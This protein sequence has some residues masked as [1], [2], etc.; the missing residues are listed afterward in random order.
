MTLSTLLRIVNTICLL[1]LMVLGLRVLHVTQTMTSTLTTLL[2]TQ[3]L[4]MHTAAQQEYAL[5]QLVRQGL[6]VQPP[7]SSQP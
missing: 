7:P 6:P 1:T 4:T 5:Q 2:A 3:G